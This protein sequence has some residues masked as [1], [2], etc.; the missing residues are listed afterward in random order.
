MIS[1][2]TL[3]RDIKIAIGLH[4]PVEPNFLE[5]RLSGEKILN[6]FSTM[7]FLGTRDLSIM[8]NGGKKMCNVISRCSTL[9]YELQENENFLWVS[10]TVILSRGKKIAS[11]VPMVVVCKVII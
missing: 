4:I 6:T 2:E 3:R 8:I 11:N 5:G 9:V 1:S 10:V 7:I